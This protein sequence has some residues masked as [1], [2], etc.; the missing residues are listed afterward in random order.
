MGIRGYPFCLSSNRLQITGYPCFRVWIPCV[1]AC[2]RGYPFRLVRQGGKSH[3]RKAAV[4]L[5]F[6]GYPG[7]SV[8]FGGQISCKSQGNLTFASQFP[9]FSW[10]SGGIRFACRQ[11]A[12]KSQGI[13]A[14]G[15]RFL[16]FSHVCGGIRSC[17]FRRVAKATSEKRRLRWVFVGIR[18]YP[19]V[20]VVKSLAN[21]RVILLLCLNALGFR[22]YPVFVL[23]V[24]KSLA[25]HRVSL[26]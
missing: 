4:A 21:H 10:V 5:G 1:F 12:C 16:V 24:V 17:W 19:L 7:A 25:N 15:F 11:I 14:L 13:F 2:I 26:L 3:F 6:R 8:G 20:L 9:R 22:G 18:E 23:L